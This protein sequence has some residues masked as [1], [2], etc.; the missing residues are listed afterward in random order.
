MESADCLSHDFI[1][2]AS[3]AVSAGF[4]LT[5]KTCHCLQSPMV[6][7][8]TPR[9]AGTL[10]V[11]EQYPTQLTSKWSECERPPFIAVTVTASQHPLE[12]PR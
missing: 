4:A 8:A 7:P 1:K 5:D 12:V 10:S 6:V 3:K 11:A 9:H 2:T